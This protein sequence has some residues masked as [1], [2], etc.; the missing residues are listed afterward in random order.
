[1]ACSCAALLGVA[2][3]NSSGTSPNT[4]ATPAD[5]VAQISVD[6]GLP[7]IGYINGLFAKVTVCVPG[8]TSDCQTI[9]HLLVDTGSSGLR[10]L[11]SVLTLS[12]PEL[13]D[14]NGVALAECTQFISGAIWGP[15]RIADFTIANEQATNLAIQVIEESTFPMPADCTGTDISTPELLGANGILGIASSMQDCGPSCAAA[16][17]AHS[18]NPGVY[19]ACSSA[20]ADGCRAASVPVA[21]QMSNPVAFF[22]QDNNGTIIELPAIPAGG[23]PS[24]TGSLVFGIGT[25]DNNN[26]APATV[27]RLDDYGQFLTSYP[28]NAT[29]QS[30]SFIDSGSNAI[31]FLDSSTTQIPTCFSPAHPSMSDFYCPS[32]TLNLSARV[33]DSYGMVALNVNFSVADAMNLSSSQYNIAFDDL[34]GPSA[35]PQSGTGTNSMSSYFDWGL[36]FFFGRNVFTAIEGR[37]STGGGG[38]GPFVAF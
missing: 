14:A 16:V 35:S 17:G 33:Q 36:P 38:A 3:S 22:S 37:A 7:N 30:L 5:N 2:C 1:M 15:L 32:S 34:T 25:R 6:Y 23:A 19:Y 13:T 20:A 18:E 29:S 28:T 31:Y 27:L 12:L 9:D 21:N 26:L 4:I 11:G 8:S 10:V 24:V